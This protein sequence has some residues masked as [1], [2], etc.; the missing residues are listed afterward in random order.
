MSEASLSSQV[1]E[2]LGITG[3]FLRRKAHTDRSPHACT[4]REVGREEEEAA[5]PQKRENEVGQVL[6]MPGYHL[7]S[8]EFVL[9]LSAHSSV[10]PA[11]LFLLGLS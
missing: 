5:S 4:S 1:A 11:G 3:E 6:G 10:L 7:F 9:W 8:G 2:S